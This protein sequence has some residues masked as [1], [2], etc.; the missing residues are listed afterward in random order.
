MVLEHWDEAR[1]RW[2]LYR[3]PG[4]HHADCERYPFERMPARVFLDTN[5]VNLIVK[6]APVIFDMEPQDPSLPIARRRDIEALTHART[7]LSRS[8]KIFCIST[9]FSVPH[10]HKGS[11]A[12]AKL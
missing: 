5:V 2:L 12:W 3:K 6:H 8:A 9:M 4:E 7:Q 11:S 1:G 10:V